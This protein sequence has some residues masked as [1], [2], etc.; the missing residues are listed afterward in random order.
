MRGVCVIIVGVMALGSCASDE[1]AGAVVVDVL[2]DDA[3]LP[4]AASTDVAPSEEDVPA[5]E[6]DDPPP[7]DLTHCALQDSWAI[8]GV[9]VLPMD[10]TPALDDRSVVISEGRICA[11]VDA[12]AALPE[13]VVVVDRP[14]HFVMPGLIDMHVHVNRVED[15]ALFVANGVTGVRCMWGSDWRLAIRDEW[16]SDA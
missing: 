10:D 13:E 9:T 6:V 15:G 1:T 8:R 4:D 14:G 11:I 3:A 2:R 7:A 5:A 12:A 16:R